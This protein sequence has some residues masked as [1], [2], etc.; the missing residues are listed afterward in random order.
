[1]M[2]APT[3][4]DVVHGEGTARLYHFRPAGEAG[5]AEVVEPRPGAEPLLK[6]VEAST[7]A[8]K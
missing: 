7:A 8:K 4:K 1:M 6:A 2:L 5:V 3:P